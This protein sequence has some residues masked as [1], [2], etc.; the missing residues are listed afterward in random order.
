MKNT[1][2]FFKPRR[3]IRWRKCRLN[4]QQ[5]HRKTLFRLPVREI[6]VNF[7]SKNPPTCCYSQRDDPYVPACIPVRLESW[8]NRLRR[9]IDSVD[10][11]RYRRI[12]ASLVGASRRDLPDLDANEHWVFR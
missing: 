11:R 1:A 12:L 5:V 7:H 8:R 6:F 3:I 4:Q 9:L 2:A 10:L